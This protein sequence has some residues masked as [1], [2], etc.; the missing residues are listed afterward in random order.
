M[1]WVVIVAVGAVVCTV[2]DHLHVVYGVLAYAH[3][4][5]WQQA[6]WV[7]L[8]FAGSTLAVLVG[9]VI[10]KAALGRGVPD[11]PLDAGRIVFASA[12]FVGAY[13]FT[14]VAHGAPNLVL[15]VLLV[16][17]VAR[18]ARGTPRWLLVYS[19]FVGLLGPAVEATLSSLGLFAYLEP[20]LLGTPRWLPGLYL[21]AGLAVGALRP[22]ILPP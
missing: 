10:T 20:D 21:H 12:A 1:R 7:A 8:L 6:W 4:D 5:V 9:S 14:A 3:P 11:P 15:G 2:C 13:A 19:V 18:V 17:W 16:F 22:W